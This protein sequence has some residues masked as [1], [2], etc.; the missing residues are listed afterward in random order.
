MYLFLVLFVNVMSLDLNL[1]RRL[2]RHVAY[3]V[4][5]RFLKRYYCFDVFVVI[6]DLNLTPYQ[7]LPHS[8]GNKRVIVVLFN[9][10]HA[11]DWLKKI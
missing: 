4:E 7:L 5:V 6:V 3:L 11:S 2:G 9:E 1:D 8:D 10:G